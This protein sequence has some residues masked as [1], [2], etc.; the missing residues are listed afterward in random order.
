MNLFELFLHLFGFALPALAVGVLLTVFSR[1]FIRKT[2]VMLGWLAQAAINSGV[3]VLV[4]WGGLLFFD[5]D[6]KMATYAAMELGGAASG[7]RC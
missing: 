2:P 5:R 6:A 7:N 3:G 1:I 4:L